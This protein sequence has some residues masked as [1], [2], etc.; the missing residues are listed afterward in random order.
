M[1]KGFIS[2]EKYITIITT[3]TVNNKVNKCEVLGYVEAV[4]KTDVVLA[5]S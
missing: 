4:I 1:Y 2:G 5:L 3:I